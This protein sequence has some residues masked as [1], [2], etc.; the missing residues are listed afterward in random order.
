[1]PCREKREAEEETKTLELPYYYAPT[2]Y[3][4]HVAHPYAL[5]APLAYHAPIAAPVTYTVP[6]PV[7][8]EIE[9]PTPT[10]KH[11]VEKVPLQPLCQNHLG[12]AVPC[13]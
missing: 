10:Y 8:K 7:V 2:I 12:L 5:S 6:E 13:A 3:N 9:V 4:H 1:M 11:V